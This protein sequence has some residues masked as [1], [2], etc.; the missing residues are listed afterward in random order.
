MTRASKGLAEARRENA[1]G[2]IEDRAC[3]VD[4]FEGLFKDLLRLVGVACFE[5]RVLRG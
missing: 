1:R 5:G 4:L 2:L 3:R